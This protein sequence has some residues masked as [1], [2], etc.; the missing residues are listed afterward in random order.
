[1]GTTENTEKSWR[2]KRTICGGLCCSHSRLAWGNVL[3]RPRSA[4]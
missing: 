3:P 1:M 2:T 4:P